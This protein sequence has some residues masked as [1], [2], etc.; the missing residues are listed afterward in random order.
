MLAF[1]TTPGFSLLRVTFRPSH[2]TPAALPF[3]GFLLADGRLRRSPTRAERVLPT[4]YVDLILSLDEHHKA[5]VVAGARSRAILIDTS[6]SLSFIGV[7][8]RPAGRFFPSACRSGSCRTIAGTPT[9]IWG[10]DAR[11]L[12]EQLLEHPAPEDRFRYSRALPAR[13]LAQSPRPA[14]WPLQ[15]AIDTIG[16][17]QGATSIASIVERTG[18]FSAR[19]FIATFRDEVGLAPK[20]FCRLTRFRR[21]IGELRRA[22]RVGR[23]GRYRG[24]HAATSDQPHFIGDF[25]RAFAGVS[26]SAYLRHRTASVN[27]ACASGKFSTIRAVRRPARMQGGWAHAQTASRRIFFT[28]RPRG[29][30]GLAD[31]SLRLSR[32]CAEDGAGQQGP[33]CRDGTGRNR[34]RHDGLAGPTYRTPKHWAR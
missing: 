5:D 16:A 20:V 34:R 12:R 30:A 9:V 3:R 23:L 19:R 28:L 26:P 15:Y 8:F 2:Q 21:V 27:H 31:E 25:G 7:R 10:S 17:S 1:H 4:G 22:R 29:G 11:T 14:A 33:A 24:R 13:T 6:R 32:P 18:S